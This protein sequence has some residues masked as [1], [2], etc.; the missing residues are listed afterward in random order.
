MAADKRVNLIRRLADEA[1]FECVGIGLAAPIRYLDYFHDWLSRGYVGR[2]DY[3][4]RLKDLRADPRK[5][6]DGARSIIVVAHNYYQGSADKSSADDDN[7]QRGDCRGRVARYSWGADYHQLIHAKLHRMVEILREKLDEPFD[8]R[9]CVDT[10]PLMEREAAAAAGIGWIGK[11]TMV[12]NRKLGSFFF[13]GEIVTTLDL[14]PDGPATDG[15]A[16]CKRCLEA[17]PTGA[18]LGP[19]QMDASRC[20]SYLTIEHRDDIAADLRPLMANWVYGCD[21]CQEVCPYNRKTPT[22]NESAY[23]PVAG[24]PLVP[25][26]GLRELMD[27]SEEDYAKYLTGSAMKRAT[28]RML[29]RNA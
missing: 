15:C 9:I 4:G 8:S 21:L 23:K 1:G 19:Y 17:C 11:N 3:L 2:M 14:P 28:R 29:K 5:L 7:E 10:A 16:A 12:L 24:N 13:L 25:Y 18:L 22:T 20:I 26:P 27:L 6:L